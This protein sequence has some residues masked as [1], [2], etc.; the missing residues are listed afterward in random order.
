[1][2]QKKVK[3]IVLGENGQRMEEEIECVSISEVKTDD[4][5]NK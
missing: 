1:M 3:T 5:E 2:E 4:A